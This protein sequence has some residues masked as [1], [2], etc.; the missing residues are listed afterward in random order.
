VTFSAGDLLSI[1]YTEANAIA[2]RIR[3]G[4]EYNSP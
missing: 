1:L 3:F 2:A 4:F